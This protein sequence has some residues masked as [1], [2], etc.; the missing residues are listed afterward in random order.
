MFAITGF[1]FGG[2]CP[3]PGP[4]LLRAQA[5]LASAAAPSTRR[6]AVINRLRGAA[7]RDHGGDGDP[8]PAPAR[9]GPGQLRRLPVRA[10]G[11]GRPHP[12][13]AGR[14]DPGRRAAG[15][16]ARRPERP[17]HELHR[18]RPAVRGHDRPR[19]GQGGA[20]CRSQQITDTLQIYMGSA[21][22]NDFDFNNRS[23]R[24]Y[25][26]ADKQFR[27]RAAGHARS[28]T[29]A[30]T[31]G[32]MV[33]LD[34]LVRVTQTATPQVITPLQPV[35]LGGD[36]RRGGARPQLGRGHRGHG[37]AER[38][39]AAPGLR[40]RVDGPLPRGAAVGAA[41]PPSS[42]GSARSSST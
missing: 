28:S 23:Y 18:R 7:R 22:V 31:T 5:L 40:L 9:A 41:P 16:R 42:S 21:Y 30:P 39:G 11:P 14:G 19:E 33:P 13:R 10:A 37:G 4:D 1:S 3:Q 15:Q 25:V 2:H 35:P 6:E 34:N 12:G 24:V 32:T 38:E 36:Q 8:L 26:Q 29:C 20:G 27:S 17:L